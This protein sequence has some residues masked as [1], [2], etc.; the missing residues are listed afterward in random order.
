MGK[1]QGKSNNFPPPCVGENGFSHV[2]FEP[3]LNVQTSRII[4]EQ[5]A[6]ALDETASRGGRGLPLSS[7]PKVPQKKNGNFVDPKE[8]HPDPKDQS[9]FCPSPSEPSSWLHAPSLQK[10]HD[11][12]FVHDG[13]P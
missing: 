9:N 2:A 7:P 5:Y 6:K 1:R 8:D 11:P 13:F 3:Q 12:L 10:K 4:I